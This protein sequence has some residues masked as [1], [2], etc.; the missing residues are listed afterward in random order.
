MG[1]VPPKSFLPSSPIG[2]SSATNAVNPVQAM[3]VN[4]QQPLLP[5]NFQNQPTM[6]PTASTPNPGGT[7]NYQQLLSGLL[8]IP[9]LSQ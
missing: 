3:G 7:V 6:N 1:Q 9:G 5:P 2:G 4:P 8:N